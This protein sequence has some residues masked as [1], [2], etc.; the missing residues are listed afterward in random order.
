[1][2]RELIYLLMETPIRDSISMASQMDS[3]SISGRMDR[4]IWA[5]LRMDRS[6]E[7]ENGR[8]SP[9]KPIAI[10][11]RESMLLIRKM[12]MESL[13]GKAA[14]FIKEAIK[15]TKETAMGRCSGRMDQFIRASGGKAYSMGKEKWFFLMELSKK[16]FSKTMFLLATVRIKTIPAEPNCPTDPQTSIYL[17]CECPVEAE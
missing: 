7:R 15:R 1:M 2:G 17:K 8:K 12:D 4:P 10:A 13:T 16:D 11:M 5:S 6:T 14:I 3:D 9:T